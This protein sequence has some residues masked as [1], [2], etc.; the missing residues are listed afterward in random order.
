[1]LDL[2]ETAARLAKNLRSDC[3]C[4]QKVNPY[5]VVILFFSRFIKIFVDLSLNHNGCI[6][7]I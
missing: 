7:L 5:L 4:Y 6:D 2:I 3:H 1:M